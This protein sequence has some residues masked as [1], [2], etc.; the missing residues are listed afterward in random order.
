MEEPCFPSS[1]THSSNFTSTCGMG[2]AD[3]FILEGSK[4]GTGSQCSTSKVM[5]DRPE[6]GSGGAAD[7]WG[8]LGGGVGSLN[9]KAGVLS[10]FPLLPGQVSPKSKG[11]C[12]EGFKAGLRQILQT[13]SEET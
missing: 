2:A 13:G 3:V 1:C 12:Q 8:V 4:R 10:A 7:L 5:G 6:A 11:H 9:R